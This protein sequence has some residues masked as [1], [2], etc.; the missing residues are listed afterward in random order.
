L[1]EW[2]MNGTFPRLPLTRKKA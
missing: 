2:S 1:L